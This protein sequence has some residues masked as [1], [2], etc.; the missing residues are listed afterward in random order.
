MSKE[1]PEAQKAQPAQD[2]KPYSEQSISDLFM[3]PRLTDMAL[4]NPDTHASVGVHRAVLAAGSKYFLEVFCEWKKRCEE[5]KVELEVLTKV[6]VPRPIGPTVDEPKGVVSDEI[7]H[8]ILK[9]LY[10]N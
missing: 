5:R 8:R 10:H 6:E 7:V 9:Y 1:A 2:A 3:N 4:V